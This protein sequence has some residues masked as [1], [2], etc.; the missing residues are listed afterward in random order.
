[1]VVR[2]V[3]WVVLLCCLL[4]LWYWWQCYTLMESG[5]GLLAER[6]ALPRFSAATPFMVHVTDTS[7]T[8]TGS[9]SISADFINRVLAAYGSPAAG[10]GQTLYDL[11]VEYGIDPVY[12]LAFFL[13]EDSFGETGIGAANHSLGNIRCSEGYACQY[14]FR[15]YVTWSDGYQDW[16]SLILNG[17]IKGQITDAI[18]GHPCVT[19]EE[20][21]PVYAP[22]S[23]HNDVA[24]YISALEHS[25]QQ[26]RSGQVWV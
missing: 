4:L 25:V 17:Y 5:R 2:V 9:P 22:S 18:V 10:T 16:Y 1:V 3:K 21:V 11:G 13:H 20:I 19:V 24:A 7:Y 15:Y 26:W 8:V 6:P 12:A 14:G 23:D